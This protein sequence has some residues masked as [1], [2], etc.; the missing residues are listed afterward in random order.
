MKKGLFLPAVLD[1][2]AD[3]FI[4]D[5]MQAHNNAFNLSVEIAYPTKDNAEV[6]VG[7]HLRKPKKLPWKQTS[8]LN[9]QQKI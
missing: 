1:I 7:R 5:L 3:Q 9:I 2:D 6:L 8:L 4:N